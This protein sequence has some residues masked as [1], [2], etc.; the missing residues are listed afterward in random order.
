MSTKD[1]FDE[2]TSL[3]VEQRAI[4]VDSLLRSLNAPSEEIDKKWAA[5]AHR[6]LEELRSGEQVAVPGDEVF[7]RI[8]KRFE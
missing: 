3:P 6:R 8:W 4:L 7:G 5:V 1:L 2:A